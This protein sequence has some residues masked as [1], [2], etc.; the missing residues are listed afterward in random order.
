MTNDQSIISFNVVVNSNPNDSNINNESLSFSTDSIIK[1]NSSDASTNPLF[2]LP[3]NS[4]TYAKINLLKGGKNK[5]MAC[6]QCKQTTFTEAFLTCQECKSHVHYECAKLPD[7][8]KRLLISLNGLYVCERCVEKKSEEKCYKESPVSTSFNQFQPVSTIVQT[9][10][11]SLRPHQSA[12]EGIQAT[13]KEI[14]AEMANKELDNVSHSL[15]NL[16]N[17]IGLVER[18]LEEKVKIYLQGQLAKFSLDMMECM[19]SI[20]NMQSQ[21][22]RE[23]TIITSKYNNEYRNHTHAHIDE[24]STKEAIIESLKTEIEEKDKTIRQL[25][26]QT[27]DLLTKTNARHQQLKQLDTE[28]MNFK[29]FP[30]STAYVE[31]LQSYIKILEHQLSL[32]N[33]HN[34]ILV[35]A[36]QR[37]DNKLSEMK[38]RVRGLGTRLSKAVEEAMSQ[39]EPATLNSNSTEAPSI[40]LNTEQVDYD[41]QAVRD[42][43]LILPEA[44]V[45]VNSIIPTS[46]AAVFEGSSQCEN[47]VMVDGVMYQ[48]VT[49]LQD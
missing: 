12:L 13:I 21:N 27:E 4:T 28:I 35:A 25:E 15:L 40:T 24:L 23:N 1:A 30:P 22:I 43:P 32:N 19:N 2:S 26:Q 34:E 16:D 42:Q 7:Y 20:N 17:K 36:S 33:D 8:C 31:Q 6:P 45:P 11:I 44:P 18:R 9:T 38:S 47:Y 48:K 49:H 29:E 46:T 39:S 5:I 10:P 3:S 41:Q 14:T 37:K